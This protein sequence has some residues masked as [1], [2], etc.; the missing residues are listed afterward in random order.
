MKKLKKIILAA[1]LAAAA[2]AANSPVQAASQDECKIW[3]C[4]PGGFPTGCGGA[5]SAMIDRVKNFKPP[6]PAF[7]SCAVNPP[8]GSGSN[9]SF[10]H[11]VAAYIPRHQE[12]LRWGYRGDALVCNRSRTVAAQH[13]KGTSCTRHHESGLT[14][15]RGCTRTDHWAEVFTEGRKTGGTYYF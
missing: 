6:L 4:L 8:E 1:T 5:K 2:F 9:M 12:C 14:T 7:S 13:V 3:L 10:S 11:G 15:P